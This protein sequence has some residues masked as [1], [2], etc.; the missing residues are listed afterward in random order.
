VSEK[1]RER[2]IAE[3][4]CYNATACIR[5]R[6]LAVGPA[7]GTPAGSAG[8]KPA[9]P[10][11]LLALLLAACSQPQPANGDVEEHRDQWHPREAQSDF[12]DIGEQ[13]GVEWLSFV[14]RDQQEY[15]EYFEGLDRDQKRRLRLAHTGDGEMILLEFNLP[16]GSKLWPVDWYGTELMAIDLP[17]TEGFSLALARDQKSRLKTLAQ[18]RIDNPR[19]DQFDDGSGGVRS[20]RE[21]NRVVQLFVP[22]NGG[23]REAY[24][25]T[26]IVGKTGKWRIYVESLH[27]DDEDVR[28]ILDAVSIKREIALEGSPKHKVSSA[29]NVLL[30]GTLH[31]PHGS[32]SLPVTDELVRKVG[33]DSTVRLDAHGAEP[34]LLIRRL[35]ESDLEGDLRVRVRTDPT[36]SRRLKQPGAKFSAGYNPGWNFPAVLWDFSHSGAEQIILGVIVVGKEFLTLEV[37]STGL[38]DGDARRHARQ[39]ALDLFSGANTA[40]VG[41]RKPLEPLLGWNIGTMGRDD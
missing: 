22:P 27:G 16:E 9:L 6:R 4:D 29:L 26:E 39:A 30:Q 35:K 40:P 11:V 32:L 25:D 34:W 18:A 37:V 31:Y 3:G 1:G 20:M 8:W 5:R 19:K 28:A 14:Q 36:F 2:R 23:S 17:G 24:G 41:D 15:P 10:V 33:G 38:R 7:G 12:L 21:S 13:A